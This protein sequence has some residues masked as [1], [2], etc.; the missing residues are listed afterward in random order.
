MG[1]AK[2]VPLA[3]ASTSDTCCRCA[4]AP[5]T[6]ST[7]EATTLASTTVFSEETSTTALSQNDAPSSSTPLE[8]T[9]PTTT[10]AVREKAA[11]TMWGDPHI[12][13]F[14]DLDLTF[15]ESSTY[16]IVRSSRISIQGQYERIDFS[17]T[18]RAEGWMTSLNVS[19]SFLQGHTLSFKAGHGAAAERGVFWDGVAILQGLQ[20]EVSLESDLVLATRQDDPVRS[21]QRLEQTDA[22]VNAQS[23]GRLIRS[24]DVALPLGVVLTVNTVDWTQRNNLDMLLMMYPE[25]EGQSGHCGNFNGDKWDDWIS[26]MTR[27]MGETP[28]EE[29]GCTSEAHANATAV[30]TE[31]CGDDQEGDL[32]AAFLEACIYDVCRAGPEVAL[33]DCL[34]AWQTKVAAGV[35]TSRATRLIGPGCCR[36]AM[37]VERSRTA[38]QD[39]TLIECARECASTDSCIAFAIS[40]CS[41][42]SDAICGGSCH[43]YLRHNEQELTTGVC[44]D[45]RLEGNTFCYALE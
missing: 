20:H 41:S 29:S 18:Q 32:A 27:L 2:A 14:D 43:L 28:T 30:C 12:R 24:Y 11:C 26:T 4:T 23:P 6:S 5:P 8:T 10:T 3:A 40:G 15:S 36:S 19:G 35:A 13:T 21:W 25:P 33:S 9:T 37:L 44:I 39:V 42:S 38:E 31:M 34:M 1:M 7:M 45:S 16:S 17:D 22:Q